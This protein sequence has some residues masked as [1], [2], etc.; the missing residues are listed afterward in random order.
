MANDHKSAIAH[1]ASEM[2]LFLKIKRV[3]MFGK[4]RMTA[5]RET[6]GIE[7]LLLRISAQMVWSRKQNTSGTT[8]KT[9]FLCENK[10]EDFCSMT[11]DRMALLYRGFWSERNGTFAVH[12]G[13]SRSVAAY[14]ELL[15]KQLSK[16]NW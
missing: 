2:R 13:G 11:T 4:V 7:W 14:L 12:N 10:W 16:K 5:I 6:L 3:T 15:P 8:S 1:L 9:N